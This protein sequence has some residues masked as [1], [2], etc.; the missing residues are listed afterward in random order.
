MSSLRESLKEVPSLGPRVQNLSP[1]LYA[2]D[3]HDKPRNIQISSNPTSLNSSPRKHFPFS[4]SNRGTMRKKLVL[5]KKKSCDGFNPKGKQVLIPKE[6]KMI[7]YLNIS[8]IPI[9]SEITNFQRRLLNT[10][11][12]HHEEEIPPST[13]RRVS[14]VKIIP[15]KQQTFERSQSPEWKKTVEPFQ[16]KFNKKYDRFIKMQSNA[17]NQYLEKFKSISELKAKPHVLNIQPNFSRTSSEWD[18]QL[19]K[20]F[21][22]EKEKEILFER[23]SKEI[24]RLKR[25][26]LDGEIIEIPKIYNGTEKNGNNVKRYEEKEICLTDRQSTSEGSRPFQ[27]LNADN[28][29]NQESL[30]TQYNDK[31]RHKDSI[32]LTQSRIKDGQKIIHPLTASTVSQGFYKSDKSQTKSGH[33]KGFSIYDSI[34]QGDKYNNSLY[35]EK[36]SQSCNGSAPHSPLGPEQN[37]LTQ[38]LKETKQKMFKEKLFSSIRNLGDLNSLKSDLEDK[39]VY[40]RRPPTQQRSVTNR[41][42]YSG[43]IS[44]RHTYNRGK[45]N[46]IFK[47]PSGFSS[48]R[49][50]NE[51]SMRSQD[52]VNC[53][54]GRKEMKQNVGINEKRRIGINSQNKT[55]RPIEIKARPAPIDL[56][57]KSNKASRVFQDK[58][59]K[60]AYDEDNVQRKDSL[61][62]EENILD[63][64][65]EGWS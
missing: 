31:E 22:H 32:D 18:T 15:P 11:R 28:Q 44:D 37:K 59:I 25:K 33:K 64:K 2:T 35:L 10:D 12:F 16:Q 54:N 42:I 27:P 40:E 60:V 1:T 41:K 30:A 56:K 47:L 5:T 36:V 62:K 46:E 58:M 14:Q 8:Q 13:S 19:I 20:N 3:L 6:N 61:K 49:N 53:P 21:I 48:P 50:V 65:L 52:L 23:K 51:F 24:L 38:A 55:K 63:F 34:T 7:K 57:I 29:E 43:S 9:H 26:V 17:L 45:S 4:F 39:M